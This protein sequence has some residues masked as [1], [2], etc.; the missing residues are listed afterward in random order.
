MFDTDV[1]IYVALFL[2]NILHLK[3]FEKCPSPKIAK[4]ALF[5]Y[6]S[7]KT[8]NFLLQ[9]DTNFNHIDMHWIYML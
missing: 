7:E 3:P 1:T 9:K 4:K 8:S 5:F 2:T 6:Y